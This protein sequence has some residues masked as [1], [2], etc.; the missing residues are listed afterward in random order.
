MQGQQ[1]KQNANSTGNGQ[2]SGNAQRR[3]QHNTTRQE[4]LPEVEQSSIYLDEPL[5]VIPN[6]PVRA[7]EG[8]SQMARDLE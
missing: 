2:N 1:P 6:P 8:D 5:I 4:Q 3:A 7:P